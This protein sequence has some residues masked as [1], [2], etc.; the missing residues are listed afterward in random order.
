M[1]GVV[2]G[3]GVLYGLRLCLHMCG[4]DVF[5]RWS[6]GRI[7][8]GMLV[9][10]YDHGTISDDMLACMLSVCCVWSE[11]RRSLTNILLQDFFV[12]VRD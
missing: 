2:V 1:S 10:T 3:V 4:V 7:L 6:S 8:H 5:R 11:R 9:S 12:D